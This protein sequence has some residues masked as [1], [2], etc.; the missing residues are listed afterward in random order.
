MPRRPDRVRLLVVGNVTEDLSFRVSEL[1][2]PGETLISGS[3][4]DDLGGKG[5]NQ[6]VI[7]A[8]CGIAVTLLAPVGNDAIADRARALAEAEGIRPDLPAVTERS[9]QSVIAVARSGENIIISSA[10]AA[11]ALDIA[12]AAAR[13]GS[14]APGD[15]VLVQG[16]LSSAV[17]RAVLSA[18]RAR[19]ITT[20]ANPSPIRW[21]WGELWTLVDTAIVNRLEL[22]TLT[23]MDDME[24]G[25]GYLRRA[26]CGRV[27]VTLGAE[28]AVLT[29]ASGLHH[30]DASPA[31]VV[32]T[33]GAGDTLCGVFLAR[34]LSGDRPAAALARAARA[35]AITVSREGTH[36]AFPDAATLCFPGDEGAE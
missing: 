20:F 32:D 6:A 27:L 12:T 1:P 35:A 18:A 17:T 29:D 3:R 19:G 2:R 13:V 33:A 9:D 7:A 34:E 11:D 16:N 22:A 5:L 10:L 36:S 24:S 23:G 21:N 31:S 14:V 26:G 28:G 8:R 25:I 15:A 4:S 30:M